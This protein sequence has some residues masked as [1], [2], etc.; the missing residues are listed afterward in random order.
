MI[1]S[2]IELDFSH[3]FARVFMLHLDSKTSAMLSFF[4]TSVN[5]AT[6]C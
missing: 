4:F 3:T 1:A 6:P 5:F 2:G